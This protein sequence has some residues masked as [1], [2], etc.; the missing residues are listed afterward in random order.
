MTRLILMRHAKAVPHAAS[1]WD[2]PLSEIGRDQS[3]EAGKWIRNQGAVPDAAI[4][5]SS[6]RTCETFAGLA[7][8]LSVMPTDD[9]YN[10]TGAELAD[11]VRGCSAD[12]DLILVV[13]HNPG[14]SDLAV[15]C[16]H[17]AHLTPGSA[18]R[19]SWEGAPCD[20]GSASVVLEG[21]FV[22]SV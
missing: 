13:A 19:V 5:S 20:F 10:A 3:L 16:G 18:V 21:S 14:V 17:S 9:A 12:A 4:V 11:L 15:A 6:R 1:D 2:R 7:L 22:P 8:D